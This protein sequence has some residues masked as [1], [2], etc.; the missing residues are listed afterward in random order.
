MTVCARMGMNATKVFI[1]LCV[2][3]LAIAEAPRADDSGGWMPDFYSY[4]PAAPEIKAPDLDILPFW[5]DD[6]KKAKRAYR[7]GEYAK[8]R[9]YFEKESEDGNIVADWYLGHIYRLGRGVTQ[10]NAKAY[11]YYSRVADR[12][13]DDER[14][15]MR[16]RI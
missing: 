2:S 9:R 12:F 14:D 5:N 1:A 3:L 10:D 4:L 15:E 13:D 6:L 8:A 11:S 7:D 16:L